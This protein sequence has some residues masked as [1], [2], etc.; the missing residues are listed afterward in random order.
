MGRIV[1]QLGNKGRFQMAEINSE[2][3]IPDIS[4]VD[5]DTRLKVLLGVPPTKEEEET[6]TSNEADP[7]K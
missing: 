1:L 3:D 2:Q 6:T 7:D 4:E 5:F